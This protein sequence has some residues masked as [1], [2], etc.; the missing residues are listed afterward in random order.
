MLKIFI[1]IIVLLIG[2]LR[3]LFLSIKIPITALILKS[4]KLI[5][6]NIV[7]L[8]DSDANA[9]I[10]GSGGIKII[11]LCNLKS[12]PSVLKQIVTADGTRQKITGMVDLPIFVNG[13]FRILR[14]L[15]VP[16]ITHSFILG[17]DL[18]RKFNIRIDFKQNTWD[19]RDDEDS[20]VAIVSNENVSAQTESACNRHDFTS[21]QIE[22]INGV[23]SL[24]NNLNRDGKLSRTNKLVHH[25]ETADAKPIK[26]RQYPL[27]PYLLGHFN[28]ELDRMLELGVV[29]P[30]QSAWSSPVLLVKKKD[31]TYRFCFDGRKLNSV[32]QKDSYPLPFGPDIEYVT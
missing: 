30:S 16:S 27:S 8:L 22:Q 23:V 6:T 10:I 20:E 26:Q 14:A 17:S 21:S 2:Q 13:S 1:A 12:L 9:S 3:L 28:R 29:E 15:I 25:I 32:T 18:C 19:I 24:F 5:D 11:S 31:D 4:V 7:A